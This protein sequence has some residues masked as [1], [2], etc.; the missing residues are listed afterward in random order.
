MKTETIQAHTIHPGDRVLDGDTVREVKE[1]TDMES[2]CCMIFKDG[3]L[4]FYNFFD[5]VKV[6]VKRWWFL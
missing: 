6:V 1:T 5:E 4:K 2:G 3:I